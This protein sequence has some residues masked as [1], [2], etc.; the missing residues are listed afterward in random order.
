ML[1]A[2]ACLEFFPEEQ[3][4]LGHDFKLK[5]VPNRMVQAEPLRLPIREP[6]Q[7]TQKNANHPKE[8]LCFF[9]HDPR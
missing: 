3:L 7:P 2:A 5:I 1:N 9:S 8:I 6:N 4:L